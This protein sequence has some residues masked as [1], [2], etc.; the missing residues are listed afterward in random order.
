MD[1]LRLRVARMVAE[2]TSRRGLLSLIA[3]LTVFLLTVGTSPEMFAQT[4][5]PV[6]TAEPATPMPT[7]AS[8]TSIDLFNW[9]PDWARGALITGLGG[10]GALVVV[11][12]LVGTA[13][14]GTAG[15]VKIAVDEQRLEV[16]TQRFDDL[17]KDGSVNPEVIGVREHAIDNL[18][19]DLL[20]ERRR[21]FAMAGFL[22]VVLGAC[23]A[24][25]LAKDLLQAIVFGASWTGLVG[26]LGL[27]QD[28]AERKEV[29]DHALVKLAEAA[30]ASAPAPDALLNEADVAKAL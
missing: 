2:S 10:F 7:P 22:Y 19:D 18:R 30:K 3:A 16:W 6:P 26:T 27:R 1:E 5:E 14:P 4:P 13:V 28:Y 23:F 17:M 8:A 20:T 9:Y 21:Q 29:K 25:L 15:A 24:A 12:T 11:F